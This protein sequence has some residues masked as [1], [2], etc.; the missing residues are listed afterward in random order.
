MVHGIW[1]RSRT[2]WAEKADELAMT[3]SADTPASSDP[4]SDGDSNSE[5]FAPDDHSREFYELLVPLK[6]QGTSVC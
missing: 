6:M 4:D 3:G 1:K 5:A 2:S